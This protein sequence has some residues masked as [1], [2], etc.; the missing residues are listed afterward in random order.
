MN[1]INFPPALGKIGGETE[2]FSLVEVTS[3]GDG[4]RWL[5]NSA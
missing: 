5:L 4:E 3:L 2:F 1:P